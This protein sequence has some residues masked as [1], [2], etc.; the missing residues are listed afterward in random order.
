M[1]FKVVISTFKVCKKTQFALVLLPIIRHE[2][3]L[4]NPKYY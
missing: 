3:D 2:M 1:A 4:S